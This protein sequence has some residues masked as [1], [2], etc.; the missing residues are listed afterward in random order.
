[1]ITIKP[2]EKGERY[3]VNG[4]TVYIDS[5]GNWIAT[6][7]L[8]VNEGKAFNNY[9]NAIVDNESL[10]SHPETGWIKIIGVS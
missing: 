7:E 4:K 1:M 2:I 6:E 8:T 10:K 3:E 9:K 5:N